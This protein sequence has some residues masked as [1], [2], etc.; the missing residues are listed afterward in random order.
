MKRSDKQVIIDSL[1]EQI[2]SSNHF[3]L[4]DISE[5]NA[6][7]TSDLRRL[8]FKQ[9]VKLVVV[10][11]TL[12]RKALE[13]SEKQADELYDVLKGNTS[14]MFTEN[15]NVPAK[16]IKEFREKHDRPILKGA[17]VEESIYMGDD[18]IDTLV[19]IKSKKELIADVVALLQSPMKTVV[20]QLQSGANILHG[21]LQTLG[22][23]E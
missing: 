18:Q 17:Y 10:K 12:L 16:L 8:C 3:Y 14:V 11:N 21:V 1:T 19:A 15:G 6:S 7:D 20:S 13:S 9:E 2:N 22:E 5:L 4:A 23:E